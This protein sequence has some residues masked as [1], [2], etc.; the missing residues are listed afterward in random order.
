MFLEIALPSVAQAL[1]WRVL[2]LTTSWEGTRVNASQM[3]SL[4]CQHNC[5]VVHPIKLKDMAGILGH[6]HV[7]SC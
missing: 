4:C 3:A 5:A 6:L 2:N 1:S 7:G